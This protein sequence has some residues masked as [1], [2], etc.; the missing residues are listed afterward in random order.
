MNPKEHDR[1]MAAV[2]HLP[3]M[4]AYT[5]VNT[6]K[7]YMGEKPIICGGGFKDFTRIAKSNPDMWCDIALENSQNILDCINLYITKLKELESIISQKDTKT[8]MGFFENARK[9][10]IEDQ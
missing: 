4:V 1:L 6:V 8:L 2:S 7:T 10:K 3:H 5:L 9:I